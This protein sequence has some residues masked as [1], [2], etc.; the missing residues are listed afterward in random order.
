MAYFDLSQKISDGMPIYPGDDEVSLVQT[1]NLREDGYNAFTLR[2]GMHSGTHVDCPM[3]L[4]DDDRTA[5]DFPMEFFSGHACLLDVRGEA[6]I[7]YHEEYE[8]QLAQEEIILLLTGMD[9]HYG[10][11]RYYNNHPVVTEQF[12]EFLAAR[13]V[14][15]LGMDMPSPDLPPFPVHKLLLEKGIFV[16]ENLTGLE[17]L[18]GKEGLEVFAVP[19]KICAEASLTRAFAR[20]D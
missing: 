7:D 2:T 9:R 8:H 16:L 13:K 5:A 12:A 10:S 14:K 17:Q 18:Q 19:L 6:E 3:H 11:E 4:L 20:C 15:M 1:K